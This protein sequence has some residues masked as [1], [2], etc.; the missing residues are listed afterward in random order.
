MAYEN[1]TQEKIIERMLQK[2]DNT[3][4]K[5]E[6][7]IVYDMLAPGSI[8]LAQAYMELDNILNFG[9]ADTSY[10][11][12]LEMRAA[13][14]GITRKQASQATGRL[15]F[16]GPAESVIPA[17]TQVSNGNE[18]NLVI[19]ETL[20]DVKII[21]SVISVDAIVTEGGSQGNVA[22]GAFKEILGELAGGLISVTNNEPFSQ[23]FDTETDEELLQRYKIRTQNTIA[24]GNDIYYR[25]LATEVPGVYDARVYPR[26]NGRGT[27]K[28]VVLSPN[29]KS[30]SATVVQSVKDKI[31]ENLM[32]GADITVEGVEEVTM[33]IDV[34]LTIM[35]GQQIP[36][37]EIAARLEDYFAS[38]AFNDLIIR[39]SRIGD[40]LLDVGPVIDYEDL[41]INGKTSNITIQ[42]YQVAVLGRLTIT[43]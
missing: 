24:P 13:E 15:T 19:A 28:V 16:A 36:Q 3:L 14:V 18:D 27:L 12:Y 29:K 21:G 1:E 22:Q 8:E 2:I 39:Y 26:W 33:D 10:G 34:K 23:G 41:R 38:L 31:N 6:G 4:D 30:P 25:L 40:A 37:E 17:G 5:R 32:L 35:E 11:P 42:D 9:F 43:T 20:F 7:S